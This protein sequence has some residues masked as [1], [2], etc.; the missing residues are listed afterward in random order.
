MTTTVDTHIILGT[1]NLE[2]SISLMLD[3]MGEDKEGKIEFGDW[4]DKI[5]RTGYAYGHWIKVPY[6][7]FDETEDKVFEGLP[8]CLKDCFVHARQFGAK[9]ILFDR[10][11]FC[12]DLKEYEW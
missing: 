10:D 1:S 4:R 2:E 6:V 9:W 3:E 8:D 7:N 5:L 12:P 11:E